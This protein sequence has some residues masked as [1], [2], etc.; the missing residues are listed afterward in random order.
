MNYRKK[1]I[2]KTTQARG[3]R[4]IQKQRGKDPKKTQAALLSRKSNKEGGDGPRKRGE[5]KK[6]RTILEP[7][8]NVRTGCTQNHTPETFTQTGS[9]QERP[10]TKIMFNHQ[11][12]KKTPK[13]NNAVRSREYIFLNQPPEPISNFFGGG[14]KPKKSLRGGAEPKQGGGEKSAVTG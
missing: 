14:G 3:P 5:E 6:V 13:K 8:K 2:I 1:A 7:E 11:R 12:K 4:G 9:I 10:P